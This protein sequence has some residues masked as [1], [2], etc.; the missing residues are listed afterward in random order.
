MTN[1]EEW[2]KIGNRLTAYLGVCS[3]QR[4]LKGIVTVL[5]SIHSKIDDS[6]TGFTSEEY[7]ICALLERK[8][9][10]THGVNCEYPILNNEEFW[11]WII[12]VKDSPYLEDN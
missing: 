3:C 12:E 10:L 4:K 11:E 2:H 7:L 6:W 1:I 8:N 9:L 5:N